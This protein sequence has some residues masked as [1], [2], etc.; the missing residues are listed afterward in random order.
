MATE[1]RSDNSNKLRDGPC[2]E[3][4]FELEKCA[5]EKNITTSHMKKMASCPRQ[6]DHLIKCMKKHPNFFHSD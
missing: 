1:Q 4:Y 5:I 6:T 3:H 2:A